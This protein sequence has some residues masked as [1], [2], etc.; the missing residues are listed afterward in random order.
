[1]PHEVNHS[2]VQN[3]ETSPEWKQHKHKHKPITK[4]RPNTQQNAH[5]KQASKNTANST[6]LSKNK[7]KPQ[8]KKQQRNKKKKPNSCKTILECVSYEPYSMFFHNYF[9]E[10]IFYVAG[11]Q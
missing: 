9:F 6:N 10:K 4:R 5:T 2:Y 1:M 3:L 7:Q 8:E 11:T